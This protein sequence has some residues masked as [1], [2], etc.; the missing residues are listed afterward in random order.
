MDFLLEQNDPQF[1]L[2]AQKAFYLIVV[3]PIPYQPVQTDC[4]KHV[5]KDQAN[6]GSCATGDGD[7]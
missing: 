2:L 7:Y 6:Y 5:E 1:V 4:R 3:D